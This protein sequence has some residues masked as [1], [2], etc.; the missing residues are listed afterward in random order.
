MKPYPLQV[1]FRE[2]FE[3]IL[4]A[5]FLALFLRFFVFSILYIPTNS[6]EPNLQRGDFVIGWRLAYG[7]PIPL[8]QGER[9]N[10]KMPKRGEVV[11]LRFPGDE[12]QIIIRRIIGLAGDKIKINGQM[13]SVNGAPLQRTQQP[14]GS[15]LET[16]PSATQYRVS[17]S[18]SAL[19]LEVEVPEGHLFVL[20]DNRKTT[21]DSRDWGFVPVKNLESQLGLV[22]LSVSNSGEGLS[23]DWSRLFTW[24]L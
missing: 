16:L 15:S 9:L 11:S 6:M 20:S 7:F 18:S 13:I 21:D 19:E 4:A 2:Y 5:I 1:L 22:W 3:G 8:S 14:D 24:V 17:L 23:I 10:S 12:E